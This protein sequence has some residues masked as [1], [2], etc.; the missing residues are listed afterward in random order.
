MGTE[1]GK[2]VFIVMFYPN[3]SFTVKDYGFRDFF[4]SYL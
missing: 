4:F 1:I 2:Q 3:K